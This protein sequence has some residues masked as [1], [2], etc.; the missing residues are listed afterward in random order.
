MPPLLAL[1]RRP[2][3][4]DLRALALMRMG[5]AAVILLDIGIRAT[6]LEAHYSNMGVL[7]LHVL[8][9]YCWTPYQ[10][11]LHA[12]S[13]LWQVQAVLFLLEALAA[14]ALL[15][16]YHTRLAT[17]GTW[18]LLVSVQNRNPLI[19][20]GGD[21]L[22]RM[23]LFWALFLP[24]GRLYSV[25]AR[26]QEPP[27]KLTY[28][29]AATVAYIVQIALVYWCTALLKSAPEWTTEGT[30]IYYALSLDQVTLPAGKL[31]YPYGTLLHWL[32]FATYYTELLLPFVL[33]IPFRVTWWRLLFVGVMYTFHL[34]ISVTL[35]VGLF[36]LINMASVLALLPP[37]AMNWLDKRLAL[38][39]QR[40][41]PRFEARFARLQPHLSRLRVPVRVH[42]EHSFAITER[43]RQLLHGLRNT[44]VAVLLGYVC[45]W[46]LDSVN[47][48]SLYMS[49]PLRWF[50]YLFRVDQ[51]WSMFAPAVFKDDGWFILDGTTTQGQH[52]DLNRD[53]Q[54]T[55][56]AK[57]A[58]VVALFKNDRWRKYTEN[59]LFVNNEYMRPY[60]CNY[61]LRI[62]H[63]NPAN[64][65]LQR[66]EV[67]Y[68]KEVSQPN[69]QVAKPVREVLCACEPER[70]AAPA[71]AAVADTLR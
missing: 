66:L 3:V 48:P 27:A 9:Q 44:V 65:P 46:N 45:W 51:H 40:L 22:L 61:L 68:M 28:F 38:G 17:L 12:A 32:T 47:Q 7:P 34:G 63:E 52:F 42:F 2:F 53:G 43:T 50:G 11:S 16:G 71:P 58:S 6:D 23:L 1:L 5:V 54:P 60:Y 20:Q 35:F 41:E 25:D 15:V 55:N 24:W 19:G 33:F 10:V 62:W 70:P 30:A 59:Y 29:S 4:L 57:P 26:G 36:F 8:Y 18:L 37:V 21:D 13:G 69:Y 67:V 39:R 56:Y 49:Q 31:L 64:P 14:A